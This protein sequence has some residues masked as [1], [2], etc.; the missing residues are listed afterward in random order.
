[1]DWIDEEGSQRW[2]KIIG[3]HRSMPSRA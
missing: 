2:R 3:A 1:M